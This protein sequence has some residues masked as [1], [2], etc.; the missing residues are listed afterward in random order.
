MLQPLEFAFDVGGSWKSSD[1]AVGE[2]GKCPANVALQKTV[3]GT[4][5]S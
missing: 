5:S 2:R 4:L 3:L 1:A